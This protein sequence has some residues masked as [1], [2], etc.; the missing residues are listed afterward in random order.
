MRLLGVVAP[1]SVSCPRGERSR[2]LQSRRKPN[3]F[4]RRSYPAPGT[5][6]RVAASRLLA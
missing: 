3:E 6:V 2:P 5:A 4:T 1:P